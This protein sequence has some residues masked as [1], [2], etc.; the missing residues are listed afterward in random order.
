MFG[1]EGQLLASPTHIQ[2]GVAPA[3][4]FMDY[5]TNRPPYWRSSLRISFR[6]AGAATGAWLCLRGICHPR[7]ERRF[8]A[9]STGGSAA[10]KCRR[11]TVFIGCSKRWRGIQVKEVTPEQ[12]GFPHVVPLARIDRVREIKGG[13]QEVQTVWIVTS[14]T[15]DKANAT[16]LLELAPPMDFRTA[17]GCSRSGKRGID[18][19]GTTAH[20][21]ICQPRIKALT[22]LS[23]LLCRC[24]LLPSCHVRDGHRRGKAEK[25]WHIAGGS[26]DGSLAA[27]RPVCSPP[28]R[29][30]SGGY[31]G[32]VE[33]ARVLRPQ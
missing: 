18:T 15:V 29:S 16:R 13:K 17:L 21:T 8:G 31:C 32:H 20:D 25:R 24:C 2:I 23:L 19:L 10:T 12:M 22:R 26:S 27:S 9:G 14:Y 6:G 28:H 3:V 1:E 7:N 5:D 4:Q 11:R 33:I 30:R